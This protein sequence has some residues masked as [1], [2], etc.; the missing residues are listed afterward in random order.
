MIR[1][2][3]NFN[4]PSKKAEAAQPRLDSLIAFMKAFGKKEQQ[5]LNARQGQ[6]WSGK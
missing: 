4:A 6:Y 5:Q 1:G 3:Q 2:L